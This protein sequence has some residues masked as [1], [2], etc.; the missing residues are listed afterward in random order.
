MKTL[1]IGATAA[2]MV[3][4][5]GAAHLDKLVAG[6]LRHHKYTLGTKLREG[7]RRVLMH[8]LCRP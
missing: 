7:S 8:V 5:T 1:K 2:A 6:C 4:L 3:L